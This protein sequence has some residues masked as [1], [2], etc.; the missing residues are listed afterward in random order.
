MFDSAVL[1]QALVTGLLVGGIYALISAGFTLVFGV[2]GILNFA[3]GELLMLAMYG[4]FFLFTIFGIH[5]YLAILIMLPALLIFG[6]LLYRVCIHPVIDA[7]HLSHVM[8]TVGISLFLQN[9][10]L[11][12]FTADFRSVQ[13]PFALSKLELGP[14][15]VGMPH[16]VA[17]ACSV[18]VTLVLYWLLRSTDLGR[19]IRAAAES[20]EAALLMGVDVKKVYLVTFAIGAACLGVAGPLLT[21]IY[22]MA[23]DIGG[24]FIMTVFAVV[25]LGGMGNFLGALAGGLIIGVAE[26]LGNF[27]MPGSLGPVVAF[28]VLILVLLFKPEGVFGGKRT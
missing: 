5:P 21:P 27:Y 28:S 22:Y 8:L 1:A 6:A 23:P 24:L 2:L 26:S 17:F 13:V 3:H 12:A 11:F 25:V 9:A 18:A 19:S 20:R 14:V 10:A 7:S 4:T 15:V 16:L